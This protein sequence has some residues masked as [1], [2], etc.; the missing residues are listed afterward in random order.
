MSVTQL[1]DV[2]PEARRPKVYV[3]RG[4]PGSGKSTLYARMRAENPRLARVSRDDARATLF[5]VQGRMAHADEELI[6]KA[7]RAQAKALLAA[8]YDVFV[9]AMNLRAYWARG[10]ANFAALNGADFEVINLEATVE[11]CIA[12]DRERAAAGG[13]S[14]GEEAIRVLGRKFPRSKWPEITPSP[15]LFFF[16]DPYV[17]DESL[18]PAWIVDLDGTVALMTGRGP[19]D[20]DRVDEDVPNEHVVTVVRKLAA[21][22]AILN[23]TGRPD[24]CRE[25]T[26]KWLE[27]NQIPFAELHMRATGDK[28]PDYLVKHELLGLV[29]NRYRILGAFDDRL[30]VARLWYRLGVPLLRAGVPDHDDF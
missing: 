16:P 18:P 9:D 15:D 14:V 20:Y 30:Q 1:V 6:T 11:E 12:R 2:I 26:A 24:S 27:R 29:R 7:E 28:R 3:P 25:A 21:D 19:H 4:Y 10:W 23:L 17:P 13:R 8:G 5:G 22:A